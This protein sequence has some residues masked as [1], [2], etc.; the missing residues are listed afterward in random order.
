MKKT[1]AIGLV[2]LCLGAGPAWSVDMEEGQR[3]AQACIGCH[4]ANGQASNPEWPNLAG[5]NANYIMKQ[6]KAFK[7]GI[8][9]NEL[10]SPMAQSLSDA[11]VENIAAYFSS[12]GSCN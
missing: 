10:M 6:L 8:R 5:Q 3:K 1:A 2:G 9:K 11:D 12:L 4:G 7:S